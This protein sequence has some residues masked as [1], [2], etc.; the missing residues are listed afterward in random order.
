MRSGVM[1]NRL[2]RNGV[3]RNRAGKE[4]GGTLYCSRCLI[5]IF[6]LFVLFVLFVCSGDLSGLHCQIDAGPQSLRVQPAGVLPGDG[7]GIDLKVRCSRTVVHPGE[8]VSFFFD[9]INTSD[10]LIVFD[11]T[12]WLNRAGGVKKKYLGPYALPLGG[13]KRISRNQAVIIP[14]DIEPG[15]YV[16]TLS[17]NK[18]YDLLDEESFSVKVEP[19]QSRD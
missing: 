8:S 17:A 15:D 9:C 18:G 5:V 19:V 11:M 6:V 2:M 4:D 1:R 10:S 7:N 3:M 16:I 14:V 13:R 12:L